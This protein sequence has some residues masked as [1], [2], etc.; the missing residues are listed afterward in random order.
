[1][2]SKNRLKTSEQKSEFIFFYLS[3]PVTSN[4]C[5]LF[6]LWIEESLCMFSIVIFAL[7]SPCS[8]LVILFWPQYYIDLLGLSYYARRYIRVYL[9]TISKHKL[10]KKMRLK[11]QKN[12]LENI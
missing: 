7:F 3:K 1:M 6:L 12:K 2:V 11:S 9:N 4:V 8:N 5:E 10:I